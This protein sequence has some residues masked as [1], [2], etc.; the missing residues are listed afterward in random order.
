MTSDR[1]TPT[2]P[3]A[4]ELRIVEQRVYRG[5]NVW[6]YEPAIHLVL[7]L[8]VLEY[9]PTHALPGFTDAPD[10]YPGRQ[11]IGAIGRTTAPA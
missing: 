7:D 3:A 2:G 8:G 1:P 11:L 9:Y 6:S 10:D 5:P 4:P